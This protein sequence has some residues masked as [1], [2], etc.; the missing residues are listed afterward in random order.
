MSE[1]VTVP[2]LRF[3]E[4]EGA[5]EDT[6]LGELMKISSASRVLKDEWTEDGVPFFRSSDVVSI[7]KG[8][9]NK[10]AFISKDLFE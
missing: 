8:T 6:K 4:F 5:W 10:K 1:A 3:P 7:Y 9:E 2:A